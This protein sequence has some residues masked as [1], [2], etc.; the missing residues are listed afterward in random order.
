MKLQKFGHL[1]GRVGLDVLIRQ[2]EGEMTTFSDQTKTIYCPGL[3]VEVA[4][5]VDSSQERDLE[6]VEAGITVGGSTHAVAEK[7]MTPTSVSMDDSGISM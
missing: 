3:P 1:L 2:M 7:V 5:D 6:E 4:G